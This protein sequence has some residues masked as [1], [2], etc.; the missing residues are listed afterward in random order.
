M[1]QFWDLVPKFILERKGNIF[2]IVVS[3]TVPIFL[4]LILYALLVRHVLIKPGVPNMTVMG[5]SNNDE[6]ILYKPIPAGLT[7]AMDRRFEEAVIAVPFV[8]RN[9][10]TF[11]TPDL[12]IRCWFQIL[13][14][15]LDRMREQLPALGAGRYPD[16]SSREAVVGYQAAQQWQLSVGDTFVYDPV[17]QFFDYIDP[18]EDHPSSY[19][20]AGVMDR[21]VRFDFLS[22]SIMLPYPQEDEPGQALLRNNGLFLYPAQGAGN[23]PL[24]AIRDLV[25][26]SHLVPLFTRR[27]WTDFSAIHILVVMVLG[28]VVLNLLSAGSAYID[29]NS[30]NI[31]L[32]Q[33]F[34]T[35]NGQIGSVFVT[36]LAAIE[37]LSFLL[38][39]GLAF[40]STLF[41]NRSYS[42]PFDVVFDYYR[43]PL[44]GYLLVGALLALLTLGST[45]YMLL[46]INRLS[47]ATILIHSD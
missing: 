32:L 25:Y 18:K 40:G 26:G 38:G 46:R 15:D 19:R 13:Y 17:R 35:E 30:K 3:I 28:I 47:P 31:G 16:G 34:G 36:G 24:E 5:K 37:L 22:G 39:L 8:Y 12:R 33:A 29:Q 14:M 1:V 4:C 42:K 21:D 2:R 43:I 23:F 11:P 45:A 7:S 20:V 44:D 6:V 9:I 10:M 27:Q 41:L